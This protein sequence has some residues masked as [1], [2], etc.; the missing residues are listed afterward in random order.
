MKYLLILTLS[1]NSISLITEVLNKLDIKIKDRVSYKVME[2]KGNVEVVI[3]A[4]DVIALRTAINAVLRN[5]KVAND[6][7]TIR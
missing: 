4:N 6:A 3:K 2:R 1:C 5:L 7:M